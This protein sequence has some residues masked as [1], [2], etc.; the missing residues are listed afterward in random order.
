[1]KTEESAT[2]DLQEVPGQLR[3][4]DS[5]G[6]RCASGGRP[7]SYIAAGTRGPGPTSP[8]PRKASGPFRAPRAPRA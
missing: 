8:R 7:L 4:D 3:P 1:M 5:A 2:F 6:G